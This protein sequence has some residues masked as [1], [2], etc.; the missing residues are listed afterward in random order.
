MKPCAFLHSTSRSGARS[1]RRAG[2]DAW[3]PRLRPSGFARDDGLIDAPHASPIT[4]TER[5][6]LC[7]DQSPHVPD[8]PVEA[9]EDGAGDD[10]EPDGHLGDVR[11]EVPEQR[12]VRIIEAVTGVH[13]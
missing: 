10:G 5:E 8:G 11:D 9:H 4:A 12:V 7:L 6:P 3:I 2:R 13:A 1:R